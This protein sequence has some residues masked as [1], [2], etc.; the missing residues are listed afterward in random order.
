MATSSKNFSKPSGV[1]FKVNVIKGEAR[2]FM[3]VYAESE[4]QARQMVEDN[5]SNTLWEVES[6]E[7]VNI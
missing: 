7:Q 1:K 6:V 3:M 2:D 5:Y 4:E